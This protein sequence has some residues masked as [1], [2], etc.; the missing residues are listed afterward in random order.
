MF[1]LVLSDK[2]RSH[3][4]LV[5]EGGGG[6]DQQPVA[7]AAAHSR[8]A[9]IPGYT[10]TADADNAKVFHGREVRK[11]PS[12]AGGMS[13][14]IHLTHTEEDPEGWTPQE[15]ARYDG[16]GHDSGREWRQGQQLES[17]G[18]ATFRSKFGADAFALHHRFYLHLDGGNQLWLSAEDGCEGFPAPAPEKK[19]FGLF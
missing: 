10:Q 17:E 12:A 5:A 14:V 7:F 19:R 8:M 11:V 2:L 4:T 6:V 9:S 18:F 1:Q 13:F 16:W 3:L 15:V